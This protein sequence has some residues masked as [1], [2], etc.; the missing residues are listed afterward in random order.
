M[1]RRWHAALAVGGVLMLG[2]SRLSPSTHSDARPQIPGLDRILKR[3]P[4]LTT[5]AADAVFVVPFLDDFDPQAFD[6]VDK[7]KRAPDGSL[8]FPPGLYQFDLRSFCVQPGTY[9]PRGREGEGAEG[10]VYAPM[11]GPRA[12]ILQHLI[13]RAFEHPEI[14]Q[15]DLQVVIWAVLSYTRFSAMSRAHQV[16]AAKL[17]TP[18]QIAELNDGALG[19]IPSSLIDRAFAAL[20][21]RAGQALRAEQDLRSLLGSGRDDVSYEDLE[22]AAVLEGES[23]EPE[24]TPSARASW[25]L[26][27]EGFF[28]RYFPYDYMRVRIEMYYPEWHRVRVDGLG[29]ITMV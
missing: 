22:N 19:L 5:S 7:L 20:P 15:E 13:A 12:Q 17:L 24:A 4:A 14:P 23:P 28:V 11:K 1:H 27:P 26:R 2:A 16:T 18:A 3:P 9:G 29:R 8:E 25:S 10:Y 6:P 21:A